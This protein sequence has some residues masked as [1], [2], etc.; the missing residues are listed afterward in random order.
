MSGAP[1]APRLSAEKAQRPGAPGRLL[2]QNYTLLLSSLTPRA[3]YWS[4]VWS[5]P[6]E[7]CKL[8]TT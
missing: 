6:F 7:A 5:R 1:R 2:A 8:S 4:P 3:L